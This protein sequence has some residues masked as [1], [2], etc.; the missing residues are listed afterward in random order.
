MNLGRSVLEAAFF[1]PISQ[2]FALLADLLRENYPLFRRQ[3]FASTLFSHIKLC[4][5]T[6]FL[7]DMQYGKREKFDKYFRQ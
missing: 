6:I 4:Y 2:E 5:Y 3:P 7:H 1:R